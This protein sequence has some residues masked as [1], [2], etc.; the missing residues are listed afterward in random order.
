MSLIGVDIGTSTCKAALYSTDG[1]LIASAA[2]SYPMLHPTPFWAELDSRR[3]VS[4]VI[5]VVRELG[6]EAGRDPVSALAFSAMGEAMTPVSADRKILANAI[7]MADLRGK[8]E[9]EAF[10][11]RFDPDE[12]YRINPNI[13]SPNYSLPKLLWMRRERPELYDAADKFLLFA[14]LVPYLLGLDAVTSYSQANRTLLFDLRNQCW[15]ER[16]CREAGIDPARLPR[17]APSGE[18]LGELGSA[19][20]ERLGLGKGTLCVLGTHDQ[21]AAAL[22]SGLVAGGGA[23]CGIGTVECITPVYDGVPDLGA[24]RA[25]GFNVE[26]HAVP[27][28]YV[29]FIYNQAGSLVNWFRSTFAAADDFGSEGESFERL[30]AEMPKEP[31]SLLVLPYFEPVGAPKFILDASGL[32]LGLRT[33]TTRGEILKAIMECE[34][35]FFLESLSPLRELG[36]DTRR[37]V[38][39]GGG[40]KSA[41]WLQIKADVMGLPFERSTAPEAG[42]LGAAMIAGVGSGVFANYKEA[43]LRYAGRG[44]VFEPD[45]MRHRVYAEKY[46]RYKELYPRLAD[47]L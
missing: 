13:V 30:A 39:S 7:P 9:M 33:S 28:L 17:T 26:H 19:A 18:V 4:S 16:L 29:S 25:L 15:S 23:A 47:I 43:V 3:V 6:A 24:M 2:R 45:P 44:E 32:I 10:A 38:A 20:A 22:G 36:I 41:A 35:Y 14:E 42:A 40:A 46:E 27:G 34:T 5:D 12:L 11:A 1:A 8:E 31:T 37:F 21:C